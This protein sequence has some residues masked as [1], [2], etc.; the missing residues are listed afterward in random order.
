MKF[1]MTY[2]ISTADWDDAVTRF[3]ETGGLTP[4]GV[5]MHSRWH[6]ASGRY[7]FLLLESD[8]VSGIYR[9]AN[10]WHDLCD[11]EVT[12]VLDDEEAAAVLQEGRD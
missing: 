11:L 12:P 3:L 2:Q 7:G 5:T 10:D 4:E 9:F 6:A 8:D 1:V